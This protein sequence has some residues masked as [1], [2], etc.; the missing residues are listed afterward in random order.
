MKFRQVVCQNF[1]YL[2]RFISL[3]FVFSLSGCSLP[4]DSSGG[5]VSASTAYYKDI[6]LVEYSTTEIQL[7][8]IG[9]LPPQ[10]TTDMNSI[11]F[12]TQSDCRDK[13]IGSGLASE[14]TGQG[15]LVKF[16]MPSPISSPTTIYLKTNTLSQCLFFSRYTFDPGVISPPIFTIS[17]PASPS[18]VSYQPALFGTAIPNSVVN[19][20]S[21]SACAHLVGAGTAANYTTLGVNTHLSQNQST[22]IYGQTVDALKN[23]SACTEL[24]TYV[25]STSGPDAPVF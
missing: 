7:K 19:F 2:I 18:R 25:H 23:K 8:L 22:V 15:V 16:S 11:E 9:Q 1:I 17:S 20:Y 5:A 13:S 21:D 12:H 24:T 10:G 6:V 3:L 14:F 4:S